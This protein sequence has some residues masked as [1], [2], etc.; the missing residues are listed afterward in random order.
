MTYHIG[1][2]GNSNIEIVGTL[3]AEI[4]PPMPLIGF[5][6]SK[7][8]HAAAA[9]ELLAFLSAPEAAATYKKYL[10]QPGY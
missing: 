8:T 6:S 1:M 4:C 10:L 3:P 9:K 5:I 7:S 2:Y